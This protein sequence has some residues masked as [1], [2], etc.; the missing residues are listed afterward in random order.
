MDTPEESMFCPCQPFLLG[1]QL[2]VSGSSDAFPI[3][4]RARLSG[5]LT[6]Y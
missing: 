2:P 5:V 1:H 3:L 6:K 4:E